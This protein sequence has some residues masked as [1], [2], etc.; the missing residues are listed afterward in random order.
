LEIKLL[1]LPSTFT[2]TMYHAVVLMAAI[3]DHGFK[4]HG[5][6]KFNFF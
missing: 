6:S 2:Y 1:L 4:Y 3:K 5:P